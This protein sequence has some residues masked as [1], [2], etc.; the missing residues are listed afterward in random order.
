MIKE[1][2]LISIFLVGLFEETINQLYY[3][4]GMKRYKYLLTLMIILRGYI[5]YY[6]L[7]S[8]FGDWKGS[9]IL[10]NIYIMGNVLGGW[11]SM[12]LETPI[13]KFVIKIRH[14][15]RRRKR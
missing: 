7:R 1:L 9:F 8:V 4:C 14:K 12:W 10:A 15:G 11:L 13:D 3:K 2:F 5:W 6:V